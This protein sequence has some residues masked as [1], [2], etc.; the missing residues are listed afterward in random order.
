MAS[1]S[2]RTSCC[3]C[4]SWLRKSP[5]NSSACASTF[6]IVSA[7]CSRRLSI[8]LLALS[9]ASSTAFRCLASSSTSLA[10]M[11]AVCSSMD[12]CRP[13]SA[14]KARAPSFCNNSSRSST[15]LASPWRFSVTSYN[16]PSNFSSNAEMDDSNSDFAAPILSP[17]P[18]WATSS[19]ATTSA[20]RASNSAFQAAAVAASASL[21]AL[22]L[23]PSSPIWR[24]RFPY[25]SSPLALL[26]SC[27]SST[28]LI[29]LK[30]SS[31]NQ[32]TSSWDSFTRSASSAP[33]VR[34]DS[35]TFSRALA[36]SSREAWSS[37]RQV[38]MDFTVAAA[39]SSAAAPNAFEASSACWRNCAARLSAPSCKVET[40]ASC[41]SRAP[42][43]S[44]S[45]ETAR[46]SSR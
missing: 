16:S 46:R 27:K 19:A 23:L 7:C 40:C 15:L 35:A 9:N 31:S 6:P 38:S 26:C 13:A 30:T 12:F 24:C 14:P 1:S 34:K 45:A 41:V 25:M 18:P 32:R 8:W 17:T 39:A 42:F 21:S 36:A 29:L 28:S 33:S 20:T 37:P 22:T 43:S 3:C 2:V 44:A 11:P 4:W 10:S 5:H